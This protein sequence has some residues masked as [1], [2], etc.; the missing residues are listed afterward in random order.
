MPNKRKQRQQKKVPKQ[1]IGRGIARDYA[2]SLRQVLDDA[3][4]RINDGLLPQLEY[5]SILAGNRLDADWVSYLQQLLG[6]IKADH[7]VDAYPEYNLQAESHGALMGGFNQRQVDK[8]FK[9]VLGVN[10]MTNVK[11]YSV[12]MQSWVTENVG[13]ITSVDSKFFEE[14]EGIV[15]RGVRGGIRPETI[16]KEIQSRYKVTKSKADLIARDQMAKLNADLTKQRQESLGVEKYIWR[17]SRDERVR[18][19]HARLNG[20]EHSWD[21]PPVSCG[22]GRAHPGG[23]FQCRCTAEPVIDPDTVFA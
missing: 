13:L 5:I 14:I 2:K 1:Q 22:S 6:G 3:F 8:Q 23:C 15:L 4:D 20:T 11:N 10:V 17:T 18:S 19:Q 12:F 7:D 9:S 16:S 21:E